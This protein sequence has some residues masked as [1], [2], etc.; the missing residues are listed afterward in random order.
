MSPDL[1]FK[2]ACVEHD[3]EYRRHRRLDSQG[4]ENGPTTKARADAR[5]WRGIKNLSPILPSGLKW[6]SPTAAIYWLAVTIGG[7]SAWRTGPSRLLDQ[8]APSVGDLGQGES[9]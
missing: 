4:N 2:L 8:P 1:W 6:L 9:P 3:F 5:L 7:K